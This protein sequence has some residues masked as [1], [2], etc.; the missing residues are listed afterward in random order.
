MLLVALGGI[1]HGED[2]TLSNKEHGFQ[3]TFP[4]TW[5][6][7][8]KIS[9]EGGIARGLSPLV[10]G[11][12][13]RAGVDILV[14]IV[15]EDTTLKSFVDAQTAF[16]AKDPGFENVQKSEQKLGDNDS[17]KVTYECV[18]PQAKV[19]FQHA[20]YY[21]VVGQRKFMITTFAAKDD[22]D[23]YAKEID[24]VIKSF[25]CFTPQAAKGPE[26]FVSKEG[27]F[28][29]SF[30]SQPNEDAK[31]VDS[32][33]GKVLKHTVSVE[34]RGNVYTIMYVDY[35]AEYINKK[36]IE[37]LLDGARDS[38]TKSET[39]KLKGESKISIG[40][41]AG[42][43]LDLDVDMAHT[44][45]SWKLRLCVVENRFFTV[46]ALGLKDEES[47]KELDSF[48]KSFKLIEINSN[49]K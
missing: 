7:D 24:H 26:E 35:P 20:A 27:G 34:K 19:R 15:R 43:D 21:A 22:Y 4:E 1:A 14:F 44:D 8:D 28:S 17:V 32:A 41:H 3:I 46:S 42:R 5:N 13:T 29:V 37:G 6:V 39:R 2:K 48:I 12:K 23:N 25:K 30:P 31:E 16:L 36:G 10:A 49:K 40:T 47:L 9:K 11:A 18:N 38:F 33:A 45:L